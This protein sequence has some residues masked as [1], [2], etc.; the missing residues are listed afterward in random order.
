MQATIREVT[1]DEFPERDRF[2]EMK[3][4]GVLRDAAGVA[5][6]IISLLHTER[7]AN[8]GNYD[9]RELLNA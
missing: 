9:I 3:E 2:R 7:L 8:G 4:S 1:L 6:D 5:R